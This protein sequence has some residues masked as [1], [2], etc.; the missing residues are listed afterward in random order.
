MR[1][2]KEDIFDKIMKLPIIRIFAPFYEKH[3][4]GLLYLFFGGLAFFL[5]LILFW[6]FHIALNIN[7]LI[8]NIWVWI[9][10][11]IF[12]FTT[13]R[14]WVFNAKTSSFLE[15]LKQLFLF[16]AG[17]MA[18]LAAEEA[19]IFIFITRLG[20]N[21]MLIKLIA[22]TAVIILNYF[23]SKYMIFRRRE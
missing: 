6:I 11:V 16:F 15:L 2:A 12:A 3:K 5:S 23:I 7:E 22:Q 4:E 18:T 14:L 1:E 20:F 9:L 21:S 13:N 8:A 10:C 17:R 19:M